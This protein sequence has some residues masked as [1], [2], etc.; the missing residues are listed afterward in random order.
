[1]AIALIAAV[2]ACVIGWHVSTAIG[3]H[4]G[5]PARRAQLR[6]YRKDRMHYGVRAAAAATVLLL[7]IVV[8]A[9]H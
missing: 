5:I 4:Q 6:G 9:L 1:M 2:V 7:I 3:V 8:L